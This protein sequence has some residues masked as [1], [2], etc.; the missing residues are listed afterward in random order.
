MASRTKCLD[1]VT[2]LGMIGIQF[3]DLKVDTLGNPK[4]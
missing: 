4:W 2:S 3:L 1:L